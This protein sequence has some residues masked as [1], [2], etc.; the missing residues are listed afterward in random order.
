MLVRMGKG[1]EGVEGDVWRGEGRGRTSPSGRGRSCYAE[2]SSVDVL[3]ERRRRERVKSIHQSVR[4]PHFSSV[5]DA[6][7]YAFY[8]REDVVVLRV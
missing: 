6:I 5:D 2:I 3:F 1:I 4:E 8:E 7:A